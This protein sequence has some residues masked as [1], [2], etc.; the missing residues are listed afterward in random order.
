M[1]PLLFEPISLRGLT[2]PHRAWVSPMC[3]YSCD[4]ADPGAVTDWHLAH[5][6]GFATGGAPLILTEAAAVTPEGRIS[7]WDAGLWHEGHVAAWRRVVDFAHGQGSKIGVQLAHAGRKGSSW[8][9]FSPYAGTVPGEEGGWQAVGPTDRPFGEYAPPRP[10]REEELAG[11][12]TAFADSARMAVEAGFDTVEVHGAHGYLLHQFR[13]PLVN[14]RA[15]RYGG[16]EEGR[17][18]LTLEVVDAVRAA[19]P[20]SA[21]VLLRVSATDWSPEVPGGIEGDLART[22]E[23]A[24]QAAERGVDLVDVSSGGN[25]AKPDIPMGPGY[26]TGFA[27]RVRREAGVATGAVGMITDPQQAEHVLRSGQADAVLLA[28]AALADPRWWHRAAVALG[29]EGAVS[30]PPQYARVSDRRVY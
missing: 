23:L 5:L 13:S 26:Q 9:P 15:D 22:V 7:P 10:L 6:G 3:Q 4:L 28:R 8:P 18:R 2:L 19:V 25:L 12:V 16:G 24:R 30:W 21:P 17:N 11:I 29:A 27:E 14:T 1:N 20:D